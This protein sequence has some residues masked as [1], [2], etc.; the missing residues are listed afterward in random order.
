MSPLKLAAAL[1]AA[2]AVAAPTASADQPHPFAGDRQV[3]VLTRNLFL[4][5]DLAPIFG[6]PSLPA[7]F[8]AVAAGYADVQAS[9]VHDRMAAVADEIAAA[10]PDLVGLQEAALYRTDV[11]ADGPATPSET[12]TIDF[13]DELL[14]ALEARGQSYEVVARFDGTDA[15]LPAGLPPR[16][17]VR[18]TD[19]IAILARTDETTAD[20]KLSDPQTG[21]YATQLGLSTVGGPIAVKRGWASVDIKIR[22]KSFRFVTTHLEAFSGAVRKAQAAELAASLPD[23]AVVVGDFNAGPGKDLVAY[24]TLIGGGLADAWPDGPATCCRKLTE[25]KPLTSRI[26]LVL[27]RGGFDTV[28]TDVVSNRTPG[29]LWASDHAGVVATLR[30]P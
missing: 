1:L 4:G 25:S 18:F 16:M 20:L 28:A 9:N 3:T 15:E 2:A 7:L 30:L 26:D 19:R 21:A 22:G 6:A 27:T 23:D 29:G 5:T 10:Q 12:T 13:L 17:D 11:P 8:G 24:D 14:D